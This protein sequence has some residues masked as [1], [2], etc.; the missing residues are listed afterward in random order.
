MNATLVY[1]LSTGIRDEEGEKGKRKGKKSGG[2][3]GED[4]GEEEKASG[5]TGAG[6]QDV[7]SSRKQ[8]EA[9]LSFSPLSL[10][11]R[12]PG[13]RAF[14]FPLPSLFPPSPSPSPQCV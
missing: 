13:S 5:H 6:L 11:R 2:K 8:Q 12:V 1:R 7:S 9:S 3:R 10:A 14:P 4:E